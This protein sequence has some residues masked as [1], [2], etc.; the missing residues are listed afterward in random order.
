MIEYKPFELSPE[1]QPVKDL[2]WSLLKS[3]WHS[4][5]RK[6]M[7]NKKTPRRYAWSDQM[8]YGKW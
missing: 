4:C 5:L 2:D 1:T 3:C 7:I 8:N 6:I